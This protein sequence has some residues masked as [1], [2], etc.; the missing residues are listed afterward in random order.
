MK[1]ESAGLAIINRHAEY[2]GGQHITGELDA[3][4]AESQR[5]GQHLRQCGLA[6]TGRIF[7]QQMAAGYHAG[8]CQ[9]YDTLLAKYDPVRCLDYLFESRAG[10]QVG[11][12][13]FCLIHLSILAL[14]VFCLSYPVLVGHAKSC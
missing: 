8:Q 12:S 11:K 10:G 7:N 2:I 3:L 1:F 13:G 9:S 4:K 6:Y 5:S 14:S